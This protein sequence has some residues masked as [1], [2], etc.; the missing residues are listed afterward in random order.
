MSDLRIGAAILAGALSAAAATPSSSFAQENPQSSSYVALPTLVITA[1]RSPM[2]ID[3][4]GSAVSVIEAPQI[5]AYGSKSLADVLRGVPGLYVTENGGPGSLSNVTLRGASPA[6]TLVLIDGI[7]VGD[8]SGIGSVF[9]FGAYSA[10]DIERIEIVRGPQSALYGSDAMGGVVN[11]ITRKGA[12]SPKRS[13]IVEAGSYGTISTR[14]SISGASDSVSYA[15]SLNGF[16]ADGFSRY[17]YRIGRI[18][19]TLAAPLENDSTNKLGGT[20]RVTFKPSDDIEIDLGF[21]RY[22]DVFRFDNPGAFMPAARDSLTTKGRQAVT[23]AFARATADTFGGLLKNQLTVY[24]SLTDRF[25]RLD[26]SCF[27]AFFNS[28]DC[29]TVFKSRRIGVEYQGTAKLGAFGQFIFG[30]KSEQ[31]SATTR[32]EWLSAPFSTLQ[33]FNARQVT[34]SVFVQHS[35]TL[36]DRL[37]LSLGGRIDAVD[38]KTVFPTWRATAAYRFEETGTKL[39]ASAG[40]GARQASLYERFSIYG[41]PSLQAEQNF[42]YDVG[43]DQSLIDG[44]LK[45]SV[46]WF[47]SWYRNLIDFNPVANPPNGQYYNVGHARIRGV[48]ASADAVLVPATWKARASFTFMTANDEDKQL[49]LLRRPRQQGSLA[50]TYTGV[51]GLE[52]EGKV[53]FVSRRVDIDNQTYGRVVM[54]NYGRADMRVSYQVNETINAYLRLENLTNAYF[55][56]VRDYGTTGRAIYAG[57]K[58]TW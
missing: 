2:T 26:Q 54:P 12:R 38:Q 13:V 24:T 52:V 55:E 11:I 17:G 36:L 10:T 6:Q 30:A 31:E 34:N 45:A 47:D 50:L 21:S 46:S 57:V 44:R 5:E 40:T 35:M 22:S 51:P 32:E 9:D 1:T 39:R 53:T 18:T 8:A 7:R 56:E 4:T 14:A 3:R 43:I 15:F 25:N 20:A 37:D 49:V 19:S 16:H 58:V 42:A 48:E 27:D 41:L 28:Y 23:T 29:N 33:T